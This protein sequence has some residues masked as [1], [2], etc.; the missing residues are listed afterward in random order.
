[1]ANVITED[2]N[3]A[4]TY[5]SVEQ[6][7]SSSSS[8]VLFSRSV[9]GRSNEEEDM[10]A[11]RMSGDLEGLHPPSSSSSALLCSDEREQEQ[12]QEQ[13]QEQG[14]E[15]TGGKDSDALSDY[16]DFE[17]DDF[18]N[19]DDDEEGGEDEDEGDVSGHI[20]GLHDYRLDETA[21]W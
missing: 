19:Q 3:T 12:Q 21:D 14:Q 16:Y 8:H 1:M 11:V 7:S 18:A 15:L 5:R 2:G 13:Q 4:S 20:I 10:D 6:F 9:S 17:P